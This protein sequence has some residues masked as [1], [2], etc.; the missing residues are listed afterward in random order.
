MWK[1]AIYFHQFFTMMRT[2]G[3]R[4]RKT[5]SEKQ[6]KNMCGTAENPIPI[7]NNTGQVCQMH[8]HTMSVEKNSNANILNT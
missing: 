3:Q 7:L 4:N 5:A 2:F 8:V 1:D 6:C